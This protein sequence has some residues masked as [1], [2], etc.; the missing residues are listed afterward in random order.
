MMLGSGQGVLVGCRY[1]EESLAVSI[2]R[3]PRRRDRRGAK[4]AQKQEQERKP[5]TFQQLPSRPLRPVFRRA[6]ML[7]RA[8]KNL[9]CANTS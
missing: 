1:R 7:I 3:R 8:P 2:H 9:R 5:I 4:S 6:D